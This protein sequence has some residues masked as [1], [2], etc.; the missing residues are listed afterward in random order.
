MGNP[1]KTN[2]WDIFSEFCEV[3]EAGEGGITFLSEEGQKITLPYDPKEWVHIHRV[4]V[5]DNAEE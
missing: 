1:I 5:A 3:F 4:P 2:R